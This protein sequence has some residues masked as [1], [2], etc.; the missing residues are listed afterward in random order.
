MR[1]V[2]FFFYF[3][4][5]CFHHVLFIYFS[6]TTLQLQVMNGTWWLL[7]RWKFEFTLLFVILSRV[8]MYLCQWYA[9][10][11][12]I[13]MLTS[14]SQHTQKNAF[15]FHQ[16]KIKYKRIQMGERTK[17]VRIGRI[18]A[19]NLFMYFHFFVFSLHV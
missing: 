7:L 14:S 10:T 9:Q 16:Q 3:V 4:L 1:L 6:C 17:Q 19:F 2:W 11:L 15:C 13:S 5:F 8:P 12:C 18:V